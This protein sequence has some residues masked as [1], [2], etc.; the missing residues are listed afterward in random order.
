LKAGAGSSNKIV[1]KG[2]GNKEPGYPQS[3]LIFEIK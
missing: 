1:Y 3:D 2:Q